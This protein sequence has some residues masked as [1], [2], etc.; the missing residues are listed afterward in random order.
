MGELLQ[1]IRILR[2]DGHRYYHQCRINQ[3]LDSDRRRV[4][5]T[6]AA[7]LGLIG[8]SESRGWSELRSRQTNPMRTAFPQELLKGFIIGDR[9]GPYDFLVFVEIIPAQCRYL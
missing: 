8:H 1:K 7:W 3:T 2:R 5:G 4:A 6:R 9:P